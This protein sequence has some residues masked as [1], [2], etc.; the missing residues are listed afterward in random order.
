MFFNIT[1]TLGQVIQIGTEQATGSIFITLLVFILFLLAMA[2]MFGISL[3]FTA[4]LVIPLLLGC[5]SYY[6]NF[7]TVLTVFFIYLA[8]I[9]TGKFFIR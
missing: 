9:F 8:L 4:I 2:L 7:I 3:E 6:G 1:Q 5:A